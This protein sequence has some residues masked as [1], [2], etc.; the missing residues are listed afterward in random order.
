MA[1]RS[2]GLPPTA[3]GLHYSESNASTSSV[4]SSAPSVGPASLSTMKM[5]LLSAFM[6]VSEA[7]AK[8]KRSMWAGCVLWP[9][10]DQSRCI[11][12]LEIWLS[13]VVAIPI[14]GPLLVMVA[15]HQLL[16]T[17][18]WSCRRL[19]LLAGRQIRQQCELRSR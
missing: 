19:A 18:F 9:L 6:Q 11:G 8:V 12:S 2:Q 1:L 17:A 14:M 16:N 15:S 3:P 13:D 10:A 4:A 5:A 7:A